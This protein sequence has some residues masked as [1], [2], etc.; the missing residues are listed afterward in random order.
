M[1]FIS[2]RFFFLGG[3]WLDSW[4]IKKQNA[5]LIKYYVFLCWSFKRSIEDL[6]HYETQDDQDAT[7]FAK[8]S[9]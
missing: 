9:L 3:I 5:R 2:R 6:N 7:I 4:A 8:S 1:P